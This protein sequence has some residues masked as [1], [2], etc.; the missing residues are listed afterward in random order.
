DGKEGGCVV[1]DLPP[2]HDGRVPAAEVEAPES[3]IVDLGGAGGVRVEVSRDRRWRRRAEPG[4]A[5]ARG[6]GGGRERGVGEGRG[7]RG[8]GGGRRG[9]R[10]GGGRRRGR[11][12]RGRGR[13]GRRGGRRSSRR[14]RRWWRR[15]GTCHA[16]PRPGVDAGALTGGRDGA[17]VEGAAR[18]R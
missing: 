10:R 17:R 8:R 9:R 3:E 16:R 1:G 2:C 4:R 18:R 13:R 14:G 12:G 7:G 6:P 11:R 5:A 15:A